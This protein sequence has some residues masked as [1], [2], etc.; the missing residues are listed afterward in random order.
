MGWGSGS[1]DEEEEETLRAFLFL[2][3]EALEVPAFGEAVAGVFAAGLEPAV[4]GGGGDMTLLIPLRMLRLTTPA[5]GLG[6]LLLLLAVVLELGKKNIFSS[7]TGQLQV[8]C[9]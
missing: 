4:G 6:V 2:A 8:D 3:G 9:N 1:E 5:G 7:F